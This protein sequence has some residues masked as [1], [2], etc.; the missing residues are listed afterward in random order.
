MKSLTHWLT[1]IMFALVA[2]TALGETYTLIFDSNCSSRGEKLEF[3]CK[4]KPSFSAQSTTIFF[5]DGKWLGIEGVSKRA[6]PLGLIKND[7]YVLVF[8]Y[9][10]LYSGIATIVLI[11]KSGRFYMSEISYSNALKVQDA[12]IE[13]GRFTVGK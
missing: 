9:P 6:F 3:S 11:K 2:K 13:A 12:T 7:E 5:R 1:A 8:D 10:V 4:A